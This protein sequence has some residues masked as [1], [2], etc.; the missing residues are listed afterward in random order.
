MTEDMHTIQELKSGLFILLRFQ[1]SFSVFD[2]SKP[3]EQDIEDGE[4]V[5]ITPEE[6]PGIRIV[7]ILRTTEISLLV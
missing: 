1:G 4:P 6:A 7:N 2:T 3:T 5:F